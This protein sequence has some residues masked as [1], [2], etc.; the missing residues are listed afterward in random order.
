MRIC[1]TNPGKVAEFGGLLAPLDIR[2]IPTMKED[3]PETGD[4]FADNAREKARGYA[5]IYPNC[6]LLSEDSGLVIPALG[7]FPGPFSARFD[8][9]NMATRRV[10]HTRRTRVQMDPLNNERVLRLMKG[11]PKSKRGAYFVAY[12]VVLDPEG[13]IAF[14][15]EQRAYG[16]I[17]ETLRGTG[18]FG[19]DPL[20]ETDTS[21][22]QTWA[23]IDSARKDLISHRSRA[24]WDLMA[25]LCSTRRVVS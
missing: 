19:Y 24:V 12:I 11:K 22:G 17:T 5:K 18:G 3:I 8:D 20:F 7:N 23:E 25:W 14:E 6:W 15:V 1:T 13:E 4:T 16:W 21:F 2:L 10:I 9:L